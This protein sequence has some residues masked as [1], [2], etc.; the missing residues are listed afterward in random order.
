MQTDM[1]QI[2]ISSIFFSILI[3]MGCKNVHK[4]HE[5][6]SDSYYTCPMHPQ[7][8]QDKPGDCPICGMKLVPMEKEKKP[9]EKK[10]G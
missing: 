5:A 8:V 4:N 10:I 6:T 9:V 3:L 7:I 1:K 2:I